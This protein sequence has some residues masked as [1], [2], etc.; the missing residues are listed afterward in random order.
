M[1]FYQH[2][3][4]C[5]LSVFRTA[6]FLPVNTSDRGNR[7]RPLSPLC[8]AAGMSSLLPPF[9]PAMESGGKTS[10]ARIPPP[11]FLRHRYALK[12]KRFRSPRNAS[13]AFFIS[14]LKSDYGHVDIY[15]P[16]LKHYCNEKVLSSM[17]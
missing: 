12:S 6:S 1:S 11:F 13:Y 14:H 16:T 5:D 4:G 17:F 3:G 15:F 10:E 8:S 9:S 7:G 2:V